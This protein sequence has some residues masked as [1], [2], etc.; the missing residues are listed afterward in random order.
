MAYD[1]VACAVKRRV[2][3]GVAYDR[4]TRAVKCTIQVEWLP[5]EWNVGL[6]VEGSVV[7]SPIL[8]PPQA[9][10]KSAST[11]EQPHPGNTS[12][13]TKGQNLNLG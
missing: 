13:K 7:T 2:T 4:V 9:V 5:V 8:P 6:P 12:V 3:T 11:L 10:R 1:R